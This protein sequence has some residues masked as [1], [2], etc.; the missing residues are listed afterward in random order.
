VIVGIK[1]VTTGT[2]E[3]ETQ[4]TSFSRSERLALLAPASIP[5]FHQGESRQKA[6]QTLSANRW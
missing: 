1:R 4:K 3:I 2:A 5:T 6:A